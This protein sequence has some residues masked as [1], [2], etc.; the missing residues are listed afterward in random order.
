MI[1][2]NV[3]YSIRTSQMDTLE[4]EMVKSTEMEEIMIETSVNPDIILGKVQ[5]QLEGLSIDNQGASSSRKNEEF[6]PRPTQNQTIGGGFFKGPIPDVKVDPVEAQET[7][8]RIEIAQM[9]RN[10]K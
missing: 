6:K 9:N 2:P 5:R 8:K 4:E 3:K 7:K 10:I 1:P